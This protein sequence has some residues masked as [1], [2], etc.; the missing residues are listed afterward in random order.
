M[1]GFIINK[2]GRDCLWFLGQPYQIEGLENIDPSKRYIIV[3]N[4]S[5]MV[6]VPLN[7]LLYKTPSSWVLKEELLRIPIVNIMFL[8]G[9]GI[10]IMRSNAKKS[11]QKILEN[12]LKLKQKINPNIIIYPEGTRTK[13]GQ[14]NPFK[15]GFIQVMKSYQMDILPITLSGVFNFYSAKQKIPNPDSHIKITIHP[16]INY[17]DLKDLSDKEIT[18]QIQQI[19]ASVYYP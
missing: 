16:A 1:A 5:S 9:I 15:R 11:Q 2:W 3:S 6:D 10:P 8:L 7:A 14:L 4:H 13:T 18:K 19:V 12:I 17:Y